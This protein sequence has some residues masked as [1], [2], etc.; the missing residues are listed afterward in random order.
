MGYVYLIN[1]VG[2]DNY[3]IGHTT[4]S[5]TVR[6]NELQ[7]GNPEPLELVD[8]YETENYVKLETFLHRKNR[9]K[10]KEGEWFEFDNEFIDNFINECKTLDKT[11]SLLLEQNPF[12][13]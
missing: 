5:V 8:Y 12:F 6:L 4:R 2:T 9:N 3:K 10:K 7:T 11:I 1:M 13:E